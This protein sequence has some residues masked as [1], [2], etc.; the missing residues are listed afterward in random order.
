MVYTNIIYI[1]L[2]IIGKQGL[3]QKPTFIKPTRRKEPP[4]GMSY[5]RHLKNIQTN[6]MTT[7]DYTL[8]LMLMFLLNINQS[9][10]AFLRTAQF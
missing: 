1:L 8:F 4:L 5:T 3:L 10:D 7:C 6:R 2:N 9:Q